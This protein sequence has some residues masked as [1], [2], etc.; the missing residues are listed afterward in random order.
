MAEV[1]VTLKVFPEDP[2]K[3]EEIRQEV[4]KIVSIDK[5][6]EEEIG[7][8]VKALLVHFRTEEEGGLDP[9]EEKIAALDSVSQVQ[10][11]RVDRL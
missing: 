10:V 11:T 1:M 9:I 7:F 2:G 6:E 3:L 8:G 5:L 4:S